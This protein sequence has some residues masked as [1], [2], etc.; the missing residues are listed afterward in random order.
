MIDDAIAVEQVGLEGKFYIDARGLTARDGYL[1]YDQDLIEL[2][3]LLRDETDIPV[4]LDE[5]PELFA[6]GSSP[7]AAL[8]CGWYSVAKY[9]PA[10]TFER[11]AVAYH[12]ASF[13]LRSLRSFRKKYWCPELLKDGVAATLGPTE[14]P[15]LHT[16]PKASRSNGNAIASEDR[17]A[18]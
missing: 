1:E 7:G 2:A 16:F 8:Y 10:F 12:I 13:E 14:E 18:T 6:P 4:V 3:Q 15:F 17:P 9:V 11:G 5:R